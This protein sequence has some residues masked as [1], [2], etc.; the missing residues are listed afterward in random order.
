M[1]EVLTAMTTNIGVVWNVTPYHMGDMYQVSETPFGIVF[2]RKMK[3]ACLSEMS[4]LYHNIL[5]SVS[6]RKDSVT[7]NRLLPR[8]SNRLCMLYE[9]VSKE[10]AKI[11]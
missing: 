9:I 4:A 1:Y 10:C 11:F 8:I 5:Y 3:V 6:F 2:S 7:F